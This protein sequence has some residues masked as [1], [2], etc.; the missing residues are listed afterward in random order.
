MK[1]SQA[2]DLEDIFAFADIYEQLGEREQALKW[3]EI[4]LDK[5]YTLAKINQ[6]PGLKNLQTDV[7]FQKLLEKSRQK[8]TSSE[9]IK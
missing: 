8:S 3:I 6:N 5:G 2:Y 9:E 4:A 7:R 1:Q